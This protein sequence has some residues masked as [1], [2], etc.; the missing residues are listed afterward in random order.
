[1]YMHCYS[2]STE[3]LFVDNTIKLMLEMPIKYV[4]VH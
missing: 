1:M 3:L 2:R 4:P